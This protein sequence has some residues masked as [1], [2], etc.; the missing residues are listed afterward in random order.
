MIRGSIT[1][2]ILL[3]MFCMFVLPLYTQ[4][5]ADLIDPFLDESFSAG[6]ESIGAVDESAESPVED[7]LF[8]V[9]KDK[10]KGSF[11]IF[12]SV[13]NDFEYLFQRDSTR[14]NKD[15]LHYESPILDALT[16]HNQLKYKN[17]NRWFRFVLDYQ[18]YFQLL[19]KEESTKDTVWD[20][21]TFLGFELKEAYIAFTVQQNVDFLFGKNLFTMGSAFL[22]NPSNPLRSTT[23]SSI[24]WDRARTVPDYST[25]DEAFPSFEYP[26]GSSEDIG[27]WMFSTSLN[28]SFL[29][30]QL[31]YLP[32]LDT[33]F[34]EFDR[35]TNSFL[36]KIAYTQWYEF[37]PSFV[38]F[39]DSHIF[40]GLD[41]SASI[42]DELT[43]H[44]EFALSFEHELRNIKKQE[45]RSD[46]A[47]L[48]PGDDIYHYSLAKKDDALFFEGIVGLR[49]TPQSESTSL[50][51]ILFELYYNGKGLFTDEWNS[52]LAD[53]DNLY[54]NATTLQ[55]NSLTSSGAAAYEGL[56]GV[57]I[58]L[59][60]PLRVRPLYLLL[61][62]SRDDL[63]SSFSTEVFYGEAGIVYSPFDTTFATQMMFEWKGQSIISIGTE[64]QYF[65]GLDGGAFTELTRSFLLGLYTKIEF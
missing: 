44:G 1:L 7:D 38:F 63:F 55:G 22:V 18:L 46:V 5:D 65:F 10:E 37:V 53:L 36:A 64:L 33:G 32:Q 28:L 3:C 26:Q 49:Y 51:T 20:L 24:A 62:I 61:Q 27:A 56:T 50:F 52:Y 34:I 54:A 31:A 48:F 12:T 58:R 60:E 23:G 17:A 42:G 25:A 14:I 30:I 11:D 47:P 57:G 43:L 40:L 39:Y 29:Y 9:N 16:L 2:S 21:D 15:R 35:S 8:F 41:I 4:E 6:T 19:D 59:Y 13:Q 45:I